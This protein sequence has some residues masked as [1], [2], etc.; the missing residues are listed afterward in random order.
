M[1]RSCGAPIWARGN[2]D[3][4]RCG[5]IQS[6]GVNVGERNSTVSARRHRVGIVSTR[7]FGSY[8]RLD[9]SQRVL[10][11]EHTIDGSQEE[12]SHR[13]GSLR[14]G[15]QALAQATKF[16]RRLALYHGADKV[17]ACEPAGVSFLWLVE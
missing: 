12:R 13:V 4:L 16:C 7:A 17:D 6:R 14:V 9:E 5:E 2:K 11:R 15:R 8:S 10:L 3:V 1:G